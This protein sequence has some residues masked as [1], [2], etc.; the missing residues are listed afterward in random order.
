MNQEDYEAMSAGL[1]A[2]ARAYP[3]CPVASCDCDQINKDEWKKG[4]HCMGHF[5]QLDKAFGKDNWS[6]ADHSESAKAGKPTK[7]K[8]KS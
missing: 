1:A 6:L 8:K 4:C 7:V 5:Q 3:N 2:A